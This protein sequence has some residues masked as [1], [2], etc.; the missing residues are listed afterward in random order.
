MRVKSLISSLLFF[1]FFINTCHAYATKISANKYSSGVKPSIAQMNNTV[2]EVHSS[3]YFNRLWYKVGAIK[4]NKVEWGQSHLYDKGLDAAVAIR[5]TTVVEVHNSEHYNTLWYRVGI[6]DPQEKNIMWSK[7]YKY[8]RGVFP[9]ISL[10]D[11]LNIEVHESEN[12]ASLYTKIGSLDDIT[13]TIL[14]KKSSLN[15]HPSRELPMLISR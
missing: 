9:S 8:D 5:G 3:R 10:K 6:I 11:H 4:E 1:C 13:Q 7:S 12:F 2:V 15:I 14:W